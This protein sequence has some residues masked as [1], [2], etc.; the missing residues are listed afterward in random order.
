MEG[1]TCSAIKGHFIV[2]NSFLERSTDARLILP[3]PNR[4]P[5]P[6]P[7]PMVSR[8]IESVSNNNVHFIPKHQIQL[9]IQSLC[10]SEGYCAVWLN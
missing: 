1:F 3:N 8:E 2:L 6:H 9:R 5:N 10:V 4:N 7:N